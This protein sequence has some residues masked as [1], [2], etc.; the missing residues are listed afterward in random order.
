VARDAP[1]PAFD[2]AVP[3][4]PADPDALAA[5]TTKWGLQSSVGRV[6]T[7]FGWA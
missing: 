4:A 5:L 2:P 1:L 7:A 3:K 6:R